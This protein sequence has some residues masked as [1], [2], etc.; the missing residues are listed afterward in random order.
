MMI[1]LSVISRGCVEAIVNSEQC[2]AAMEARKLKVTYDWMDNPFDQLITPL[3]DLIREWPDLAKKVMDKC[4]D[5]NLQTDNKDKKDAA[6]RNETADSSEFEI[7]VKYELLDDTHTIYAILETTDE[8][9]GDNTAQDSASTLAESDL[10]GGGASIENN[11]I[12]PIVHLEDKKENSEDGKKKF[13]TQSMMKR[14]H[15]L[16]I[17]VN[18]KRKVVA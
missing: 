14:N 4:I 9:E 18:E 8:K 3:R 5:A 6:G 15:P 12:S 7:T 10:E 13:V 16:M 17:M 11:E 1:M 2:V